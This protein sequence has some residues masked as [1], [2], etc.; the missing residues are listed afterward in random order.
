MPL[1]LYLSEEQ[2]FL[3]IFG[4]LLA[5]GLVGWWVSS[6]INRRFPRRPRALTE[7]ERECSRCGTLWYVSVAESRERAPNKGEILGAR[8]ASAGEG[9]SLGASFRGR[10]LQK[11]RHLEDKQAQVASRNRCPSC[12]SQAFSEQTVTY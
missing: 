6:R 12:G 3:L 2:G 7:V 1:S 8:I 11:L 4:G 5:A 9:M 10:N